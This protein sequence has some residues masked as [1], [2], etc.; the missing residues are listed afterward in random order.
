MTAPYVFDRPDIVHGAVCHVLSGLA[1][2]VSSHMLFRKER[3]D[4]ATA[5]LR[6]V[7]M[8]VLTSRFGLSVRETSRMV[9]RDRGT[10]RYATRVVEVA[11]AENE[12]T[13]ALI[14]LVEHQARRRLEQLENADIAEYARGANAA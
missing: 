5:W 10:V 4:L 8:F 2:I 1:P 7:G 13:A 3:T 9:G 11:I 14:D 6:M 12:V